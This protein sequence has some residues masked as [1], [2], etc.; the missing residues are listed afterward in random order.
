MVAE[1][2]PCLQEAAKP[3]VYCRRHDGDEVGHR[4]RMKRV[5]RT[6]DLATPAILR[7][8]GGLRLDL[9]DRLLE[10]RS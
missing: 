1:S 9:E 4:A 6:L 8:S 7:G 3:S 5:R 2:N 10:L